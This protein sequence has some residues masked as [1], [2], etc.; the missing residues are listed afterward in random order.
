MYTYI[1]P[2]SKTLYK[3][4]LVNI[5]AKYN[6]FHFLHS[7]LTSATASVKVKWHGIYQ[8][9]TAV[10]SEVLSPK[11]EKKRRVRALYCK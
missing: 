7:E 4:L 9:L 5:T 2:I 8:Y 10:H 11:K 1:I 3:L 6:Q